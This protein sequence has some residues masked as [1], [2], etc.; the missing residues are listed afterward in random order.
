MTLNQSALPEVTEVLRTADGGQVMRMMLSAVLQAL[1]DAEGTSVIGAGAY[2]AP[3]AGTTAHR[4][5]FGAAGQPAAR[6]AA[7]S[8]C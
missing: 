2:E 6:V 7:T 3:G 8:R 4:R 5:A 1:V